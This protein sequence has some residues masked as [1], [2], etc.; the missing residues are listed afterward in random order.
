MV[1][2]CTR[3][4]T[5]FTAVQAKLFSLQSVSIANVWAVFFF[6]YYLFLCTLSY[7]SNPVVS[8]LFTFWFQVLVIFSRTGMRYFSSTRHYRLYSYSCNAF[9]M[10]Y[11]FVFS[12]LR[13]LCAY[14]PRFHFLSSQTSSHLPVFVISLLILL[15]V[16][17]CM[18]ISL[19]V[20]SC[21]TAY[22]TVYE[23]WQ[24]IKHNEFKTNE[25]ERME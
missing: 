14:L 1:L 24:L 21:K 12:R 15:T 2:L 10:E 7:P 8:F 22:R 17:E 3:V 6:Y 18:L 20:N 23:I 13:C 11:I 19:R 16:Y 25:P 9:F 5:H 4:R